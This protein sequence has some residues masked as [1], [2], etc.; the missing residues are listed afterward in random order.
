MIEFNFNQSVGFPLE[1]E[2]LDKMQQSWRIHDMLGAI[3]GNFTIIKGC[4]VTGSSVSDGVVF[5]NDKLLKFKGGVIQEKVVI[6]QTNEALE[7][8]DGNE[9]DVIKTLYATFGVATESWNWTDFERIPESKSIPAALELKEDKTTTA[10][11]LA[12]ITAL[13]ARPVSNVPIGLVAIWGQPANTIPAGWIPYEPLKGRIPVGLDTGNPL[14]DT[15]QN[16]G[17]SSTHTNTIA[18][19]AEH[20]HNIPVQSNNA[21]GGGSERTVKDGSTV[22]IKS[23]K[24]GGGQPYS[25]MNPFR[26][27]HFIQFQG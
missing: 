6:V 23:G 25:I 1:T 18:E 27:V 2:I 19:M 3:A 10:A 22:F 8:E 24:A 5:M 13:E 15:L 16:Y 4:V 12:R 26:V 20:D 11:L 14:F 17:G 7:F 21:A 9:R